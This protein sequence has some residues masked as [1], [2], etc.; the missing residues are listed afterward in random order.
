MSDDKSPSTFTCALVGLG[1]AAVAYGAACLLAGK[2]DGKIAAFEV[3]ETG[4]WRVVLGEDEPGLVALGEAL[5]RA[6]YNVLG[7]SHAQGP[8]DSEKSVRIKGPIDKHEVYKIASKLG[9]FIDRIE[10]F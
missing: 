2:K 8:N 4:Y 9:Y 6:G 5:Y 1:G 7:S 10:P 3:G